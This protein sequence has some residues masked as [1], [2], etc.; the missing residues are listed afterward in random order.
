MKPN[1][2]ALMREGLDSTVCLQEA[3]VGAG[4]DSGVGKSDASKFHPHLTL[5]K[6][7]RGKTKEEK[8]AKISEE[9]YASEADL[10]FG[11]Q[12]S[13]CLQLCSMTS[14]TASDGYV[15]IARLRGFG[16]GFGVTI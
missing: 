13:S 16:V 14:K 3:I 12:V 15:R 6:T 8:K 2:A 5:L 7:S 11:T 10:H 1:S 9:Q 4:F